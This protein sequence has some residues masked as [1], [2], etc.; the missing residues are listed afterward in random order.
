MKMRF[1]IMNESRRKKLVDIENILK[2]A[3]R[4]SSIEKECSSPI[5]YTG[6]KIILIN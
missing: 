3:E 5:D 1:T 2:I 4:K 6:Y